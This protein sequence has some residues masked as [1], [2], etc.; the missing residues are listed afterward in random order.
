LSRSNR[1]PFIP[2]RGSDPP[3]ATTG[4]YAHPICR[5]YVCRATTQPYSWLP[6]NTYSHT[7]KRVIGKPNTSGGR[8][9]HSLGRL[10]TRLTA[11]HISRHVASTFKR[12]T[13]ATT[14]CDLNQIHQH[15]R[16]IIFTMI[17]HIN[18]VRHPYSDYRN[19]KIAIPISRE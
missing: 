5:T 12:L 2:T 3:Q 16:G 4:P 15:R 17:H 14:H 13:T 19:V 6:G 8:Y 1:L 7:L 18:P 10:V 9:V 11:Y